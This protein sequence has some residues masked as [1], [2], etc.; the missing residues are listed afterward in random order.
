MDFGERVGWSQNLVPIELRLIQLGIQP[1]DCKQFLMRSS[2]DNLPAIHHQNQIRRQN[3]GQAILHQRDRP[4]Q[5]DRCN[6]P[7]DIFYIHV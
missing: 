6:S 3:C 1:V 7:L 5:P 4:T 2:L